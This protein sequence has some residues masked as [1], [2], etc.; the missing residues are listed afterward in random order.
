MIEPVKLRPLRLLRTDVVSKALIATT[1]ATVLTLAE[2]LLR[3]DA[4]VPRRIAT[5]AA[6]WFVMFLIVFV[7]GTLIMARRRAE[8]LPTVSRTA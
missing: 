8:S 5:D 1:V 4:V 6:L 2:Y 3:G 7:I